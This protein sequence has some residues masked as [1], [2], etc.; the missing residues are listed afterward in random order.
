L[1]LALI[2]IIKM[3]KSVQTKIYIR[4][5]RN[6]RKYFRNKNLSNFF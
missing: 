6:Y 3:H 2:V 4:Q 5:F 1:L